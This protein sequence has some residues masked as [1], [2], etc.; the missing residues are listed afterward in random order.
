[1]ANL[2]RWL[3]APS[4]LGLVALS[5]ALASS[6]R[7]SRPVEA[8]SNAVTQTY[9]FMPG[10]SMNFSNKKYHRIEIHSTFPVRIL[11]GSCHEEYVVEF[12]C[13]GEPGDVFVTDRRSKPLFGTPEANQITITELKK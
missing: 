11:T 1:M 4:A 10:Q 2:W 5:I 12:S 7:A 13:V 3:R 8:K 9:S 6:T